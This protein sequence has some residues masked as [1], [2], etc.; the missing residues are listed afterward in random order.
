MPLATGVIL[1]S[2]TM[3]LVGEIDSIT[4]VASFVTV[5]YCAVLQL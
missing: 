5:Q 2:L 1:A 4:V 3:M